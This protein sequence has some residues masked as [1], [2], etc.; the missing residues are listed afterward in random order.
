MII[1]KNYYDEQQKILHETFTKIGT[2]ADL[3]LTTGQLL[4]ENGATADR[5]VRETKRVAAFMGIPEEKFHLHI[6]YTTLML[7][8]SDETY[9]HTK[10]RKCVK[11]SVDMRIISSVSKLTWRALRDHYTL[12]EFSDNLQKISNQPRFYSANQ[13]ILATGIACGAYCVLFG[14]DFYAAIY[15]AISSMLGKFILMR[16]DK[17]GINSYVSVSFSAFIATICAYFMYFLPTETPWHPIIACALYLVPGIPIINGLTD[18]LNTFLFCGSA[19]FL[20]A[21]LIIGGMTFG[22]VFAIGMFPVSDFTNLR[23]LPDSDYFEFALFAAIGAMG[24][25][26]LFNLPPR[27]L[28]AVGIGG[29]LAVCTR[30]FLVFGL[31][32][33]SALGTLAGATLVSVSAIKAMHWLHTPMQVLIVPA[34]IPLVPGVLIYRFLFAVINI[35]T[36]TLAQLLSAIQSG[37]DAFLITLA[38]SIGAAMPNIFASRQFERRRLEEQ[39]RLLNEEY[40]TDL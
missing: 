30:N 6:M 5:I 24:F 34:M 2:K 23:M 9:S 32:C 35:K 4:M 26:I 40:K 14:G 11:H 15:T 10:F 17:I 28:Y 21:S 38:I 12:E 20:R 18:L 7:N 25:A 27:L 31:N 36:M 29:A 16:C 37:V 19:R 33:S 22:I 3:I 1:L 13:V 8:R 39:E